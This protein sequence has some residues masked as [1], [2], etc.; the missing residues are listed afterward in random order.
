[1]QPF[2][3]KFRSMLQKY[4][5]QLRGENIIRHERL[6][7]LRHELVHE[8]PYNLPPRTTAK[9]DLKTVTD[10][11]GE[12]FKQEKV[13][14]TFKAVHQ[15]WMARRRFA[16]EQGNFFQVP[17]TVQGVANYAAAAW[18]YGSVWR[19]TFR[20]RWGNVISYYLGG[21]SAVIATITLILVIGGISVWLPVNQPPLLTVPDTVIS[22][23]D[24][25]NI[26][27]NAV[28]PDSTTGGLTYSLYMSPDSFLTIDQ[29]GKIF[30]VPDSTH[31]GNHTV[32]IKAIDPL[33][34]EAVTTINVL[35]Q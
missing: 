20:T 29:E 14:K 7:A 3:S 5:P 31:K 4:I 15:L 8:F 13:Y 32:H 16:V 35:V 21:N 9:S 11:A 17:P 33:G 23:G 30:G 10:K 22:V 19:S 26:K 18:N 28:D 6:F 25:L 27:T 34:A 2:Q 1:M 24:T 12:E